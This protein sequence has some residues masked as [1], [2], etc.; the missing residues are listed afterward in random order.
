MR[1]STD[2]MRVLERY[3]WPGNVR[4]LVNVVDYVIAL[5]ADSL[6]TARDLPD[7]CTSPQRTAESHAPSQARTGR[8]VANDMGTDGEASRIREALAANAY[9]RQRTAEALGMDRVTLYRKMR[10]YGIDGTGR[11]G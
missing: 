1:L 9:H 6:V 5:T 8:Y 3:D 7:S 10:E 2:A 11:K 4:E